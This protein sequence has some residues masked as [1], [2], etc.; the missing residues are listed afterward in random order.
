M[1]RY[2]FIT[3]PN[4]LGQHSYK[5]K[6]TET[7]PELLQMWVA[8]M[9]FL[10]L[11]EIK[12]A[13]IEYGQEH[14]F[15]YSYASDN[16]YQ[17]IINWEKV[18]HGYEV[19]KDEIILIDG[20]V[21]AISVA[22]QA[23]TNKG[24]AVLINSP[25][26]YP[27][28]RT[29]NLNERKLVENPLQ[30][31]NGHFEIDFETLEKELVGNDVKVYLFCSPHNP[32]G[33]VWS[34]EEIIRVADLCQKHDVLLIADEIHQDL[35]LFGN[36]HHSVN[37]LNPAY[38]D[39]TII[40]GSATKTFNIAGIKNS[41]AI[42][43]NPELRKAFQKQQLVNNQHEVPTLGM[44]TT[45]TALRY[46]KPWLEEL[47]VVLEENIIYVEQVLT[48]KTQIK[49]MKPEGTYLIWLDFSAYGLAQPDLDTKLRQEAKVVLNDGSQ[50]GKEGKYFARLNVATPLETVKEAV[51][52]LVSVF[53]N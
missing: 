21:P 22:L 40:L 8:D 51:E 39:F 26:Y 2:D 53:G 50:F 35:T 46:G 5:W 18:E 20:V 34:R 47:K 31:K 37:T 33:R 28:A 49:V 29:I 4:R 36:H 23:L 38:K 16:L 11:P 44:I 10:P 52:R 3:R 1:G 41:F 48:E 30:I 13:I 25:V 14:V 7:D 27:F 32:G 6:A 43:Q 9:D 19:K 42:I 12:E 24:D 45:E 15:G 17:S